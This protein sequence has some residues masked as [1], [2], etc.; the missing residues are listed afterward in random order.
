MPRKKGS[1]KSRVDYGSG[2]DDYVDDKDTELPSTAGALGREKPKKRKHATVDRDAERE[3]VQNAPSTSNVLP[4]K[5]DAPRP[6]KTNLA[7]APDLQARSTL[8]VKSIVY[9]SLLP[10]VPTTVNIDSHL[11]FCLQTGAYEWVHFPKNAISLQL[12]A[13]ARNPDYAADAADA[14]NRIEYKPTVRGNPQLGIDPDIAGRGFFSRIEVIINDKT[15]PTNDSLNQLMVHYAR[16]QAIFAPDKGRKKKRPHLKNLV[17]WNL[18]GAAADYSKVMLAATQPFAQRAHT[19]TEGQRVYV[20]MDGIFPFDLKSTIHQAIEGV[21]PQDLYFPPSTKFEVKLYFQQT[22]NEWLMHDM[23]TRANYYTDVAL[24]D[25]RALRLTIKEATLEYES[26]ELYPEKH[27][28]EMQRYRG[29]SMGFFDYDIPRAQHQNIAG[30]VSYAENTFQ[31]PPFCRSLMIMFHPTRAVLHQPHLKR[32]Q[33]AWS[34]FPLG[35]TKIQLEYAQESL[36]GRPLINFGVRGAH[37]H[38]SMYQYYNYL[39]KLNL[40]NN[41]EYEDI[42]PNDPNDD[43]NT[44]LVQCLVFDVRH[45]MLDKIQLLRIGMEFSGNQQSPAEHQVVVISIHPNG[46]ANVRNVSSDGTEWH[47]EFLQQN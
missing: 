26:V 43:N 23:V 37:S 31:I 10:M 6:A 39:T 45:L 1:K 30:N 33:S 34:T 25:P 35:C 14:A 36:T 12:L 22:K 40:T 8:G 11:H 4:A 7:G 24:G 42:F 3:A 2:S 19:D 28:Q 17:E 18:T 21:L 41:L 47:W 46:R 16:Y 29:K 44:S 20:P 32:P 13:M 15:V 5:K 9:K 27:S 38:L